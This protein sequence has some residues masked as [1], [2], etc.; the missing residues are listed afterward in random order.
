MLGIENLYFNVLLCVFLEYFGFGLTFR[1]G[2]FQRSSGGEAFLSGLSEE[3]QVHWLCKLR[4]C[5]AS[6]RKSTEPQSHT[7]KI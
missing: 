6:T 7:K 2:P 4:L 3:R 1:K 5:M